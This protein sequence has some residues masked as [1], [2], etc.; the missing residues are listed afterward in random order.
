MLLTLTIHNF[1]KKG[2]AP[3]TAK[4][5]QIENHWS[6]IN[7]ACEVVSCVHF[8]YEDSEMFPKLRPAVG[9]FLYSVWMSGHAHVSVARLSASR[10]R[11]LTCLDWSANEFQY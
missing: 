10:I 5:I 3:T 7:Y 4:L 11:F 1:Y 8:V 6:G 2:Y 9:V